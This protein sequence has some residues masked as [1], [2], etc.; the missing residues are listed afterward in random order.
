MVDE[1]KLVRVPIDTHCADPSC[2]RTLPFGSWAY[3]HADSEIAV[4]PDC[5]V[6]RGWSSKERANEIIK[7]MELQE[8]IKALKKQRKIE[9]DALFLLREKID[10]HRLG[11]GTWNLKSRFSG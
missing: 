4:C 10:L 11:R 9:A 2:K 6:K 1:I 7:K 3:Y 8:D 5:G